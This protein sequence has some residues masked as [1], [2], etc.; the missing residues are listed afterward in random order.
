[1]FHF[2]S[3]NTI[4]I[5]KKTWLVKRGN[6]SKMTKTDIKVENLGEGL[7]VIAGKN[8]NNIQQFQENKY[9]G[10]FN[11]YNMKLDSRGNMGLCH[12][13]RML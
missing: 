10:R 5:I 2:V 9:M 8:Y 3:K 12:F 13:M 11:K 7:E 4:I 1:M 6:D